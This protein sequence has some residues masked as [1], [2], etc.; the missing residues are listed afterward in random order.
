[1]DK[2]AEQALLEY[3]NEEY[4]PRPGGVNGS[5]F[6][7]TKATQFMFTPILQFPDVPSDGSYLYTA[8][9]K[10][11]KIHKQKMYCRK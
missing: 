5:P 9:D 7:N 4:S 10:N 6:W 8:T 3:N 2:Y 1:M 11:G